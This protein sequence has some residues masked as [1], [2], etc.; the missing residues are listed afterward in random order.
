V[1]RGPRIIILI[2]LNLKHLN[3]STIW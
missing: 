1:C 3:H 2:L